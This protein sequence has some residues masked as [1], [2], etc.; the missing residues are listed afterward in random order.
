MTTAQE[1]ATACKDRAAADYSR[2]DT[3]VNCYTD[4][5][6][7]EFVISH[8]G[9]LMEQGY[10]FKLMDDCASVWAERRANAASLDW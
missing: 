8:D 2:F 4:E 7:L 10:A 9:T 1:I 6:W 3:F 5:E